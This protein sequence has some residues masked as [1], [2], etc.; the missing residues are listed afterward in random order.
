[1]ESCSLCKKPIPEADS[2]AWLTEDGAH[3][4]ATKSA[5]PTALAETT[6]GEVVICEDCYRGRLPTYFTKEDLAQIH[7]QFGL[8]YHMLHDYEHSKKS[9]TRSL[10]LVESADVLAALASTE[11][12]S[13]HIE[14]ARTLYLRAL[15]IQPAHFMSTENLKN[16]RSSE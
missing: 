9:L 5:M 10:E 15:K 12:A 2:D 16:L 1:M 14:A 3:I 11:S 7:Y 8:E 4:D 13:G 6:L